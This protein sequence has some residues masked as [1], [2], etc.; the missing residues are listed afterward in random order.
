[1]GA[2]VDCDGAG[3]CEEEGASRDDEEACTGAFTEVEGSGGSG[4]VER[5]LEAR[6]LT[7]KF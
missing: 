1:M 3:V 5:N 4:R 6:K 7:E 2:E